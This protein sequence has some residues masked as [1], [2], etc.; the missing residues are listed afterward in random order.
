MCGTIADRCEKHITSQ[1][2]PDGQF[3][4]ACCRAM[5]WQNST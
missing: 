1:Y 3:Y 5:N 2:I 4:R